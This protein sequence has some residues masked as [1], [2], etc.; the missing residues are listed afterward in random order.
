MESNLFTSLGKC[1]SFYWLLLYSFNWQRSVKWFAFWYSERLFSVLCR[2]WGSK[3]WWQYRLP[4]CCV[5]GRVIWWIFTNILLKLLFP[6]TRYKS[7]MILSP[8]L[9]NISCLYFTKEAECESVRG[10]LLEICFAQSLLSSPTFWYI[11]LFHEIPDAL[12]V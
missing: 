3:G 6:A 1:V 8:L 7:E 5:W 4:S 10:W 11:L 2:T 12:L 9:H